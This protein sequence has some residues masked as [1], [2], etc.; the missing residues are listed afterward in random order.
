MG[1]LTVKSLL[2]TFLAA[3][4]LVASTTSTLAGDLIITNA[5]RWAIDVTARREERGRDTRVSLGRIPGRESR[6]FRLAQG[7]WHLIATLRNGETE[8]QTVRLRRRDIDRVRF[9]ERRDDDRGWRGR[10]RD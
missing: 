6:S 9:N 7:E 10:G 5:N 1:G 3:G 2:R 8:R 4:I